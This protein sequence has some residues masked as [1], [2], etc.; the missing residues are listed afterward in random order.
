M[1]RGRPDVE[2]VVAVANRAL[3]VD[4]DDAVGIAVV[5]TFADSR[6]TDGAQAGVGMSVGEAAVAVPVILRLPSGVDSIPEGAGPIWA[7][8]IPVTLPGS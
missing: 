2:D 6:G 3:F 8:D 4:E 1:Q 7:P 5:G